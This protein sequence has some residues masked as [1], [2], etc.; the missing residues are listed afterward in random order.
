[1]GRGNRRSRGAQI[2]ALAACLIGLA[3]AGCGGADKPDIE[4]GTPKDVSEGQNNVRTEVEKALTQAKPDS[5]D[6]TVLLLWKRTQQRLDALSADLY[7]PKVVNTIG[8]PALQGALNQQR[9][10]YATY[11]PRITDRET[12]KGGDILT[13]TATTRFE[14]D[15]D[16]DEITATFVL[17]RSKGDWLIIY[18]TLL[19]DGLAAFARLGAEGAAAQKKA[20]ARARDLTNRF[21]ALSRDVVS[22]GN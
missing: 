11:S 7:D 13:V 1:V 2:T 18:D 5:P 14:N 3:V 16:T 6:H 22:D 21:R 20:D 19:E 12:A 8:F 4:R 10:V 15:E 17:R 9:S